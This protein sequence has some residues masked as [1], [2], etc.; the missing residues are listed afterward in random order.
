MNISAKL[1][2]ALLT[3]IFLFTKNLEAQNT[4]PSSGSAGIGTTTPNASSALEIK[5]TTQGLL[6]SRM[7]K[8]QRDAIVTPATGLMVYQTN[9]TP[10]FYYYSGTAWTAI[11]VKSKG[12]SLTGNAGTASG[13]NFI[14]TT[15]AQPL[16]FK[17]NN[18]K[19]G[20]LD[21]T[22][23]IGFGLQSLSSN[24]GDYNSAFGYQALYANTT[25]S[26]NTANGFQS[27]YSNTTGYQNTANGRIA[28]F[29]NTIG[30]NNTANGF[31]SL[32]SNTAGYNNTANGSYALTYNT[33]GTENT[34]NGAFAL[35]RNT[36]GVYNTANG[37][38]ALYF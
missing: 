14:G 31:G 25:G 12:W 15:D 34:A 30:Y 9:S 18:T 29:Y 1:L 22:G 5:S 33:I 20:F 36:T 16:M 24:T 19:A 17:V 6:I 21:F 26:S 32:Y 38:N 10:G 4:F 7:T 2:L 35:N 37:S 27:I 8:A 28:L 13:A 11:T 23:N 3:Q